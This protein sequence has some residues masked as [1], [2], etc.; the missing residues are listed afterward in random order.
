VL[1]TPVHADLV[2][3]GSVRCRGGRDPSM[4]RRRLEA[5]LADVAPRS[6]GLPPR[7]WLFVRKVVAPQPLGDDARG[8]SFARSL[9][10][11]LDRVLRR[12]V[13]PWVSEG[14]TSADAVLFLDE[15][16]LAACLVRDWVRRKWAD[17]WWWR[18]L[19]GSHG[20]PDWLSRHV[21]PQAPLF[22][23]AMELSMRE[24]TAVE[25][26][27]AI[28]EGEVARVRAALEA[29]YGVCVAP[30][31]ATPRNSRDRACARSESVET[32][33]EEGAAPSRTV[34]TLRSIAPEIFG[35]RLDRGRR[36][37]LAVALVS[38]RNP[39]WARSL[40]FA[41]AV[42]RGERFEPE[43]SVAEPASPGTSMTHGTAS[44]TAGAPTPGTRDP[45]RVHIAEKG[46]GATCAE[47]VVP[48]LA[49]VEVP[50]RS[51]ATP[52]RRAI[53]SRAPGVR[54]ES[55]VS[56]DESGSATSPVQPA[57]VVPPAA[58]IDPALAPPGAESSP[59]AR[60]PSPDARANAAVESIATPRVPVVTGFG[61][62]FYLLNV[63]IALGLYGDFSQPHHAGIA[64]SPWDWL[65]AIGRRWFGARFRRDPV[66]KALADLA[67]HPPRARPERGFRPKKH[68]PGHFASR[69]A[70]AWFDEML[71][72]LAAR[73]AA[74][75]GAD[76]P[77]TVP[78]RVCRHAAHIYM[79][80]TEVEVHL[81]LDDLPLELRIA[82]LDRD[83]GWVPAAGRSLRFHFR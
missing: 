74:A 8:R 41:T 71:A 24:G 15:A 34:R 59:A 67:G 33:A 3:L 68:A 9:D 69:T 21:H 12:A 10:A 57:T 39:V 35:P 70:D 45:A 83:P 26:L 29:A 14:G 50:V 30:A 80:A 22:A 63:A 77:G 76:D 32:T 1:V 54:A 79:S 40:E 73:I 23:A 4:Q 53:D 20:V 7:A 82:G 78:D 11:D 13:R 55:P 38:R 81:S 61:G 75:L 17:R 51:T 25:W 27:E 60:V 66:W 47:E 64:L 65:A 16:E 36:A 5:A 28:P 62:I 43:A 52:P 42:A 46:S 48:A 2:H 44:A 49:G 19:L 58:L 37:L 72:A 31:L 6:F 18:Q 56:G